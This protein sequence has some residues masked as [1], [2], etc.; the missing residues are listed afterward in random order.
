VV[1]DTAA[2]TPELIAAASTDVGYPAS[3]T[4]G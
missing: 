2:T 4:D 1:Y 3:V